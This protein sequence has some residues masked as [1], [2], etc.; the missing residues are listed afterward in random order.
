MD[1]QDQEPQVGDAEPLAV[2]P[3]AEDLNLAMNSDVERL[4]DDI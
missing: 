2:A 1:Q 4:N 3:E